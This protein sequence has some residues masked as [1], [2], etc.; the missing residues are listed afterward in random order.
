[1]EQNHLNVVIN[2]IKRLNRLRIKNRL[3]KQGYDEFF[4]CK[5]ILKVNDKGDYPEEI[6]NIINK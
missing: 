2:N 5:K 1:M 3:N 4:L 6:N